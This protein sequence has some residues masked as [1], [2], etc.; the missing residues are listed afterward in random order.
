MASLSG[1]VGHTG[2]HRTW[3]T[4][5]KPGLHSKTLSKRNKLAKAGDVS[6]G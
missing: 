3:M 5:N 6:Q 2:N 4:L 1:M